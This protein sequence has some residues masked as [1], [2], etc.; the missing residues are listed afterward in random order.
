MT[1]NVRYQLPVC[2]SGRH[3]WFDQEDADRCCD[4]RYR[5]ELRLQGTY[6]RRLWVLEATGAEERP[7]VW[8]ALL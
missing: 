8:T 7:T 6:A 3:A 4:P 1:A 5:R 2:R